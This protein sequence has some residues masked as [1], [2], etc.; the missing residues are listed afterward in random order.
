MASRGSSLFGYLLFYVTIFDMSP[1]IKK[2]IRSA[3]TKESECVCE[4]GVVL[5]RGIASFNGF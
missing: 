4:I 5:S 3:F 2:V 1:P